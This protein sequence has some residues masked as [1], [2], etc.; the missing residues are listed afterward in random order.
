ME[1]LRR[2]GAYDQL[3]ASGAALQKMQSDALDAAGIAHQICG[4]ET[5]FDLYFTD[6]PCRD[7]RSAYHDD[8]KRNVVY[9]DALRANGIF[10]SPAKLY[11]SLAVTQ[12][13]LAQT[14]TAVAVAVQA[15]AEM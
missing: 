11:P 7:Y 13:D 9:N 5:L 4:D 6:R 15:I 12:D 8:P 2:D 3:R 10:K 14:Q 1:I